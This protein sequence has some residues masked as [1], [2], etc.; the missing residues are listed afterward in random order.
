F[1]GVIASGTGREFSDAF[2]EDFTELNSVMI[3]Y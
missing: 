3:R 2:I 1:G